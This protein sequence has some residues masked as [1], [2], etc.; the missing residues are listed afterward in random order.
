MRAWSPSQKPLRVSPQRW[1]ILQ[2]TPSTKRMRTIRA[3]SHCQNSLCVCPACVFL[4]GEG[5]SRKLLQLPSSNYYQREWGQWEHEALVRIPSVCP[6]CES[7]SG[8]KDPPAQQGLLPTHTL[9][10]RGARWSPHAPWKS[11][12]V[13]VWALISDFPAPSL[14]NDAKSHHCHQRQ[15]WPAPW[16]CH[17]RAQTHSGVCTENKDLSRGSQGLCVSHDDRKLLCSWT[18]STGFS[19]FVLT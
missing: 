11:S 10:A 1:R 8:V 12:F 4:R 15:A 9:S 16:G 17:C 2:K 3:W 14:T 7:S 18:N 13:S 5:F 19:D 6:A